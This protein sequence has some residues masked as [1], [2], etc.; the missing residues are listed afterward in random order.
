M[1]VLLHG[2]PCLFGKWDPKKMQCEYLTSDNLC[3]KYDE[4]KRR[5]HHGAEISPAFG[6]GCSSSMFNE[7]REAKIRKMKEQSA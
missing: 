1:R 5:G 4:I 6:A 3:S 2:R 7:R